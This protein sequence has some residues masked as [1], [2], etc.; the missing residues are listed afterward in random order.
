[1]ILTFDSFDIEYHTHCI[2]DSLEVFDGSD[3]SAESLAKLCGSTIPDDLTTSGPAILFVF[4]SDVVITK[5]GFKANIFVISQNDGKCL[6]DK[7]LLA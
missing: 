6:V 7:A 3:A 4:R 2:Y 1:M 5:S